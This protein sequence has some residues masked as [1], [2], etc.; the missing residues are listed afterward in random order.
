MRTNSGFYSKSIMKPCGLLRKRMTL[1]YL[2][3]KKLTL[4]YGI[5]PIKYK[6]GLGACNTP[7]VF[8]I[9]RVL[10]IITQDVRAQILELQFTVHEEERD[11]RQ[12]ER[13]QLQKL[14]NSLTK[15]PS[16]GLLRGEW[17]F[18]TPEFHGGTPI[19][20]LAFRVCNDIAPCMCPCIIINVQILF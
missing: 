15:E 12:K 6:G 11:G 3:F 1:C 4:L 5:I 17:K 16:L 19:C 20:S 10:A 7:R 14:F 8:A 13:N 2:Y 9:H 18:S